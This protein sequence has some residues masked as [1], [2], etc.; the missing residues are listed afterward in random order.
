MYPL[1]CKI[2]Q[3]EALKDADVLLKEMLYGLGERTKFVKAPSAGVKS[4]SNPQDG[5]KSH[6][7]RLAKQLGLTKKQIDDDLLTNLSVEDGY[8]SINDVIPKIMEMKNSCAVLEEEELNDEDDDNAGATS[9]GE[10]EKTPNLLGSRVRTVFEDGREHEGTISNVH[11]RVLYDDKDTETFTSEAEA[12]ENLAC[13]DMY[14]NEEESRCSMLE[15]FSGC[16]LLSTFCKRKGMKVVSIGERFIVCAR[17][18]F[19]FAVSNTSYVSIVGLI[20]QHQTMIR[21]PMQQ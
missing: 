10:E 3:R 14:L 19:D 11:Y 16:S 6:V 4:S 21:I 12:Y 7:V 18:S 2:E 15:L 9:D 5:N 8:Y 17:M 13:N 20:Y 1:Y